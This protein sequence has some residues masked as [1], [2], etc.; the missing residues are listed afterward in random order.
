[1]KTVT[2]LSIV[3]FNEP[4]FAA[5]GETDKPSIILKLTE[6]QQKVINAH[7]EKRLS[8]LSIHPIIQ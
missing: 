4:M 8:I 7:L 5:T 6:E 1:M 3:L 2:E